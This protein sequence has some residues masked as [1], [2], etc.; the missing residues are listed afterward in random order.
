MKYT[1]KNIGIGHEKVIMSKLSVLICINFF[2]SVISAISVG[3]TDQLV[4]HLLSEI[5]HLLVVI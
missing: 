5:D 1:I 2:L 4:G 3:F